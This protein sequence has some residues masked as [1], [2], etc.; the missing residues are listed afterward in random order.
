MAHLHPQPFE[1]V[2]KLVVKKSIF[3]T[4]WVLNGVHAKIG[5]NPV[6]MKEHVQ[7]L[8]TGCFRSNFIVASYSQRV[9]FDDL[10]QFDTSKL[11]KNFFT[12]ESLGCEP[13]RRCNNC[14]NCNNFF[15]YV[16]IL[17]LIK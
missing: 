3:G 9:E 7:I 14:Q 17:M 15:T 4:G 5:C 11:D 1:T 16:Y 8:R 6:D 10:S 13:P 2:D 12:A